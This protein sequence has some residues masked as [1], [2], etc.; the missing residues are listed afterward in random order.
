MTPLSNRFRFTADRLRALP[1]TANKVTV[2]SDIDVRKLKVRVQPVSGTRT[3]FVEKKVLGRAKRKTLGVFPEMSIDD[4][5]K[6]AL[7]ILSLLADWKAGER[8]DVDPMERRETGT[9]FADLFQSYLA[10]GMSRA[11]RENG[12]TRPRKQSVDYRKNLYK[13]YLS[14]LGSRT[15]RDITP[16]QVTRLHASLTD[17]KGHLAANRAIELARAVFNYGIK[18]NLCVGNPAKGL[19][20]NAEAPRVV[21]L[22]ANEL[23]ALER[24]L[25]AEANQDA[26]DY[27]RLDKYTGARKSN[28][29]AMRWDEVRDGMW[30]VPAE[31][32]KN[33][34]PL[35]FPLAP[36]A[37]RILARRKQAQQD[38]PSEWVFPSAT[39]QSGHVVDYKKQWQRIRK[40]AGLEHFHFHDFRH[41]LAT[42]QISAGSSLQVVGKTLGHKSLEATSV[43]AHVVVDAAKQ[44]L[45]AG[46]AL[47][48]REMK[49]AQRLLPQQRASVK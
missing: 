24:A 16:E 27:V 10:Q 39:A 15:V 38:H 20:L 45:L 40:A 2:Y 31:K 18:K 22:D 34:E 12:T 28:L 30:I 7:K 23:A 3:F 35:Y 26:V 11:K 48:A 43:Y 33:G 1:V 42:W 6:H 19:E 4:A 17:T 9:T 8:T 21:S 25:N 49:K 32:S 14:S 46:D 41:N 37:V 47:Q 13:W 44:S 29:L 5:R 36:D